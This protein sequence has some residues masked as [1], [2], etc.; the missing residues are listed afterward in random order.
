[1]TYR[2]VIPRDLFNEADFLKCLG[3]LWVA[4]DEMPSEPGHAA[5][6]GEP[7]SGGFDVDQDPSDGSLSALGLAFYIH[8]VEWRLYRPLNARESWPLWAINEND[9][10]CE[11][12]RV[13]E[14]S[15]AA[16][17]SDEFLELVKGPSKADW[18]SG[19]NMPGYLPE[20]EPRG[21]WHSWA[22]AWRDV[23]SMI[24]DDANGREDDDDETAPW[25]SAERDALAEC[26]SLE[27]GQALKDGASVVYLGR[28]FFVAPAVG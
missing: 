17:L 14:T 2:R 11:A 9:S 13:F 12:V 24:E 27:N 16:R 7:A 26:I 23:R 8:G 18:V 28:V 25:L 20:T 3:K 19:T 5:R 4:L 21:P 1:M 6:W 10:E 15:G 22:D